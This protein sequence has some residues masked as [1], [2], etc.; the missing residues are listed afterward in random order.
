[1]EP[2]Y[3]VIKERVKTGKLLVVPGN[4]DSGFDGLGLPRDWT[5]TITSDK[6][7]VR[8]VG[9]DNSQDSIS[10]QAWR[11][12]EDMAK[13]TDQPVYRFVFAHKAPSDLI[14]PNGSISTHVMGEG[15]INKDAQRLV[16]LL[17]PLDATMCVGHLHAFAYCHPW[18][19]DLICEGRGGANV[20]ELAYSLI[21]VQSEGWVL[22]SVPVA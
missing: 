13:Q 21:V 2:G 5:K 14:L 19:G 8:L 22:H 9:I 16:A 17:Q 6:K 1:L 18:W 15:R 7:E 4:H 20:T 12:L 10:A 11:Y 3:D